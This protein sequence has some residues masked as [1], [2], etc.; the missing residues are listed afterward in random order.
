MSKVQPLLT[1]ESP[2]RTSR[3]ARDRCCSCQAVIDPD[4]SWEGICSSSSLFS[5]LPRWEAPSRSRSTTPRSSTPSSRRRCP[6]WTA[7]SCS[8]AHPHRC[9]QAVT[10]IVVAR[11]SAL[12]GPHQQCKGPERVHALKASPPTRDRLTGSH[13]CP[14]CRAGRRDH[15]LHHGHRVIPQN[16]T[17]YLSQCA[18]S[19]SQQT[20]QDVHTAR[21][22]DGARV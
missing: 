14:S 20:S 18:P 16:S 19:V 8:A 15:G 2:D 7:R 17:T 1:R 10:H 3:P 5:V 22:S 12:A 21:A 4:H 6:A 9:C 13:P 11:L